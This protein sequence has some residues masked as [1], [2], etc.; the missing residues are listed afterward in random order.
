M[1]ALSITMA[2]LGIGH[3]FIHASSPSINKLNAEP[4]TG[5]SRTSKYKMPFKDSAGNIEQLWKTCQ[6]SKRYTERTVDSP[7]PTDEAFTL[8]RTSTL[9]CPAKVASSCLLLAG[10][11]INKYELVT[12][13][14][15]SNNYLV[16]STIFLVALSCNSGDLHKGFRYM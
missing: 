6:L 5:R 1:L 14:V 7:F 4:V 11:L 8:E 2:E 15:V 10:A 9:N 3:G 13:V 16:P 12:A